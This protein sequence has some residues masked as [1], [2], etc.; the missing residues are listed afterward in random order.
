MSGPFKMKGSSFYGYGNSSPAKDAG[1]DPEKLEGHKHNEADPAEL[2]GTTNKTKTKIIDVSGNWVPNPKSPAKITDAEKQANLL[3]AVPNKEAYDKL[4]DA[5]KEGFDAT[6]AKV[7]L[8]TKKSPTK[9]ITALIPMIGAKQQR[10]QNTQSLD[11]QQ[12]M[13]KKNII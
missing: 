12:R 5:D 1:H 3:K 9:L 11:L 6:G 2:T 7:G 8:P 10:T 4:S 13:H